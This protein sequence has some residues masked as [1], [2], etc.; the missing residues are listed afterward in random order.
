MET[1]LTF[2]FWYMDDDT[3][4][5]YEFKLQYVYYGTTKGGF[6]LN[7]SHRGGGV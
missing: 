6:N 5:L 2:I 4:N 7:H 3:A 1:L